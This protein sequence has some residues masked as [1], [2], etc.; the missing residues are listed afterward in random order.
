MKKIITLGLLL[1]LKAWAGCNSPNGI[2][3]TV[4]I[5]A[6][7]ANQ[8]LVMSA[9][10]AAFTTLTAASSGDDDDELTWTFD[11]FVFP[12]GASGNK[13]TPVAIKTPA[14]WPNDNS[15]WGEKTVE[16]EYN[17]RTEGAAGDCK[18]E[19]EVKVFFPP[20]Q[21]INGEPAWFKYWKGYA[22]TAPEDISYTDDI[23]SITSNTP[24][25]PYGVCK[26]TI[27]I[28]VTEI[29]QVS[30]KITDMSVSV[31]CEIFLAD[32]VLEI[33]SGTAD[34]VD[35]MQEAVDHERGHEKALEQF[36][37]AIEPE[38]KTRVLSANPPHF[39]YR[40]KCRNA[41]RRDSYGNH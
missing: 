32:Q 15:L 5:T 38:C 3:V 36:V 24:K 33:N 27:S 39:I 14:E 6:P 22:V 37:A 18:D 20:E 11:G 12:A 1:S 17:G 4:D 23:D 31:A 2:M 34:D 8:K 40:C 35:G 26:A 28:D 13:G 7:T 30:A 29:E 21:D 9:K 41:T 19:V 10:D 16:L 25:D